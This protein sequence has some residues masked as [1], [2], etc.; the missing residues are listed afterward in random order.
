MTIREKALEAFNGWY[1]SLPVYKTVG[2]PSRGTIAAALVILEHLKEKFDLNLDSHRADTGKSQLKG[3][4]GGALKKIL[5]EHG[6]NRRFLSEGGRTNRGAAGAIGTMLDAL[7]NSGLHKSAASTREKVLYDLQ[8]YLVDRVREYHGRQRLEIS[9]DPALTAWWSVRGLL[10][11]ARENGK[12]GPVAQY[13]V[14]AKLQ[15]RF[16]KTKIGNESYSTADDQLDRPGDFSF[17]DT[18]FHVTVAP[19]PGIYEKCQRNIDNGLRVF[20]LVPDKSLVGARQNAEATVAGK[21]A[22]ESIESFVSQNLEELSS[23]SRDKL[24]DG[25]RCLL[26]M[27]NK[28]VDAIETDKSLLIKIPKNLLT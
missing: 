6:E 11:L 9:Y 18:S 22:V 26:K 10:A 16:P 5:T 24:K 14:G 20:L 2:G 7:R 4:S 28:R 8:E 19:M 27:Y 13:L 15:L 1:G 23:F 12:E 3:V 21:I 25:F 17:G